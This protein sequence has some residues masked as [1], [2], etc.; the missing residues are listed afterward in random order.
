MHPIQ[1]QKPF[2]WPGHLGTHIQ[3]ATPIHVNN[4]RNALLNLCAGKYADHA[5]LLRLHNSLNAISKEPVSPPQSIRFL[6]SQGAYM[7]QVLDH[8]YGAIS[9]GDMGSI[10]DAFY[11]NAYLPNSNNEI[12]AFNA[13]IHL[14]SADQALRHQM[15]GHVIGLELQAKVKLK[16]TTPLFPTEITFNGDSVRLQ[17]SSASL[18]HSVRTLVRTEGHLPTT[19]PPFEVMAGGRRFGHAIIPGT[20][21]TTHRRLIL[22]RL[23]RLF[24][25]IRYSK[26]GCT[27]ATYIEGPSHITFGFSGDKTTH[28]QLS[29]MRA[30]TRLFETFSDSQN[31][32]ARQN[33]ISGRCAAIQ[34]RNR[35]Q[36]D[37]K[38]IG[39]FNALR[40]SHTPADQTL[41]A[42]MM[43]MQWLAEEICQDGSRNP[44]IALLD[45]SMGN[46]NIGDAKRAS[47]W[48]FY[49]SATTSPQQ[50]QSI[51]ATLALKL[52]TLLQA[53]KRSFIIAPN[54]TETQN[55]HI[56]LLSELPNAPHIVNMTADDRVQLRNRVVSYMRHHVTTIADFNELRAELPALLSGA[57]WA[58]LQIA[59]QTNALA[60][61]GLT[62][63]GSTRAA[64]RLCIACAE[65]TTY[66]SEML[67][68]S[69]SAPAR[70]LSSVNMNTVRL[71]K[72]LCKF[73]KNNVP[74]MQHLSTVLRRS[75]LD[76]LTVDAVMSGSPQ[77]VRQHSKLN[78]RSL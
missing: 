69:H 15:S 29:Q 61:F 18:Q 65:P 70:R 68:P 40:Q 60:Q 24:F 38:I 27:T 48:S 46:A 75:S 1:P 4:L 39:T 55:W 73:D 7:A 52:H 25:A 54:S 63:L 72:P 31:T 3:K 11:H 44:V 43:V 22:D 17:N 57:D 76:G 37:Q 41:F 45:H 42:A 78:R 59:I 74:G 77:F 58:R 62:R 32:V 50:R 6:R 64:S 35:A 9:T 2:V 5:L 8:A 26:P 67:R 20:W 51:H 36:K 10:A 16:Y 53:E 23:T 66:R 71:T 30:A 47:F 14:F 12:L 21:A 19:A 33:W 13:L 49:F 28:L 34:T 56:G